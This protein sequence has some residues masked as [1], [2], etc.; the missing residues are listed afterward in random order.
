[1]VETTLEI[2]LYQLT[3]LIHYCMLDGNYINGKL[4]DFDGKTY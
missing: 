4:L 1:M 2:N 3:A